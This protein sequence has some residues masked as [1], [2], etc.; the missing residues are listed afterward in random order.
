ME[1]AFFFFF[2]SLPFITDLLPSLLLSGL[3]PLSGYFHRQELLSGLPGA[4][5][6]W[7]NSFCV[8]SLH[9][10]LLCSVAEVR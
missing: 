8:V 2:C 10:D 5:T 6:D 3:L 1:R 9:K 7:D 4:I